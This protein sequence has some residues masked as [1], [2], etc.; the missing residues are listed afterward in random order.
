MLV[1]PNDIEYEI[2]KY[3][4]F[5]K[6]S[7]VSKLW[8]GEIS[9]LR[10]EAL[11]TIIRWYRKRMCPKPFNFN[12]FFPKTVRNLL[13]SMMVHWHPN[14]FLVFPENIINTLGINDMLLT[15]LKPVKYRTPRDI[16]D[17]VINLPLIVDDFEYVHVSFFMFERLP[18]IN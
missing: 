8:S 11:K 13:R 9:R 3:I 12:P 17:W 1:L 18:E 15:V 2:I 4:P 6:Y 10:Y 5:P 7:L 16:Y 14:R